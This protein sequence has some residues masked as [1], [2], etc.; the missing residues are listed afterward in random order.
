MVNQVVDCVER[1]INEPHETKY[2]KI[3]L[4]KLWKKIGEVSGG[5]DFLR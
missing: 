3:K 2:H 1:I 5:N 4:N